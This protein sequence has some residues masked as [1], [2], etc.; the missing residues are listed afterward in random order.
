MNLVQQGA[1]LSYLILHDPDFRR[2]RRDHLVETGKRIRLKHDVA[3]F[4]RALDNLAEGYKFHFNV[5]SAAPQEIIQSA[6]D[7]IVPPDHIFGT[8]F[9]YNEST[10]EV[11]SIIRAAAGWGKI[12]VLEEL[13]STLAISHNG[14]ISLAAGTSIF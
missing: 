7:G 13:R 5:I 10:G 8:R 12:T 2:V 4:A 3:L 6:L 14:T 9:R 11:D 1:E